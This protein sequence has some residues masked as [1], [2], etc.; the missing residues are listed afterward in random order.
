MKWIDRA[1]A[2]ATVGSIHLIFMWMNEKLRGGKMQLKLGAN[3]EVDIFVNADGDVVLK[4]VDKEALS[5]QG[6]DLALHPQALSAALVKLFGGAAWAQA[7]VGYAV[8]AL[9]ALLPKQP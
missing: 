6:A 2:A 5:D 9:I 7:V 8:P 3:G 1:V 4:L